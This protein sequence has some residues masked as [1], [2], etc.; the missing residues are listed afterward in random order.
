M[1][2]V[3]DSLLNGAAEDFKGVVDGGLAVGW[4]G[5]GRAEDY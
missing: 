5:D 1:F 3:W 4:W 2:D